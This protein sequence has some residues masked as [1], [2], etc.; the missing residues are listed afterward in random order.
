MQIASLFYFWAMK[1]LLPSDFKES[2]ER[3]LRYLS[4]LGKD[5]EFTVHLLHV[6]PPHIEEEIVFS[7]MDWMNNLVNVSG[8]HADYKEQLDETIR[9]HKL[10][11]EVICV[12]G[13]TEKQI[14]KHANSGDYDVLVS[15]THG[16]SGLID[17]VMGTTTQNLI[18]ESSIPVLSLLEG[19][20][21]NKDRKLLFVN[22]FEHP[23]EVDIS[24]LKELMYTFSMELNLLKIVDHGIDEDSKEMK[25]I[26][27]F[28]EKHKLKHYNPYLL[29]SRSVDEGLTEFLDQVNV[30]MAA[31]AT[32]GRHGIKHFLF[33]S[34][35]E[36]LTDRIKV[37]V[38]TFRLHS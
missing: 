18:H 32:H 17:F 20:K 23:E 28:A 24:I 21:I 3:A 6:L 34:I 26:H 8:F 38:L 5:S 16:T 37:P 27:D 7:R 30:S 11:T 19:H 9:A 31:I 36:D 2:T 13:N 4:V 1:I 25:L 35:A 12:T 29:Q 14:L 10:I 33:G 15:C 22:D